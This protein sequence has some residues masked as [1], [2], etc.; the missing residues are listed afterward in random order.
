MKSIVRF[1]AAILAGGCLGMLV[2]CE[3]DGTDAGAQT[4]ST[5]SE[6]TDR[7]VDCS[8]LTQRRFLAERLISYAQPLD[9]VLSE[10][11]M[12]R[13]QEIIVEC[14][15]V[16]HCEGAWLA[17]DD[18]KNLEETLSITGNPVVLTRSGEQLEPPYHLEPPVHRIVAR[19]TLRIGHYD[20]GM[21]HV[22]NHPYIELDTIVSEEQDLNARLFY[23]AESVIHEAYPGMVKLKGNAWV[24]KG[25]MVVDGFDDPHSLILIAPHERTINYFE[26]GVRFG[27]TDR[28]VARLIGKAVPLGEMLA[29]PAGAAG[30]EVVVRAS[31]RQEQEGLLLIAAE[32]GAPVQEI[33][34]SHTSQIWFLSER[35]ELTDLRKRADD[36]P[37]EVVAHGRLV[38][39]PTEGIAAG[40]AAI[41]AIRL[42]TIV[43]LEQL[44]MRGPTE[45]T[46]GP[47]K[48]E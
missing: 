22:E 30:K 48:A 39:P 44:R 36:P 16:S 45:R 37:W 4:D 32:P 40:S 9:V 12:H 10:V 42:R 31:L 21:V 5:K 26:G 28:Y 19:G 11:E 15:W 33:G 38:D 17:T 25:P 24:G 23:D 47:N 34:V 35:G 41:P 3:G 20:A 6:R 1:S 46:T 18:E 43:F 27:R 8:K 13:D 14:F 29:G 7:E 2:S